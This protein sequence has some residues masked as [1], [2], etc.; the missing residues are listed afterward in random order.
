MHP[1]RATSTLFSNFLLLPSELN[2]LIKADGHDK[3]TAHVTS[4]HMQGGVSNQ[5]RSLEIPV[6]KMSDKIALPPK[7]FFELGY[8]P[9]DALQ[10]QYDGKQMDIAPLAAGSLDRI[11][12][13]E[14]DSD[15]IR[16]P[17]AWLIQAFTG[18]PDTVDHIESGKHSAQYYVDTFNKHCGNFDDVKRVLDFGCGCGR[19]L[20]RMPRNDGIQYFGVDLR[21][22]ALQ[23]LRQTM[24]EGRF[25]S[26]TAMPPLDLD[27]GQ[28][29]LIY[30]VSVLTH[31]SQ[32]QEWAWLDE[33]HRLLKV[34][35][36]LIVTFRAEDWV[37]Q[38]TVARQKQA[39]QNA[40]LANDGFCYQKHRYWE[41][42]FPEFY[43]G[44]Y[45]TVDY[46]RAQ[47][48][49]RFEILT[50]LPAADTPNEQNTAVMRK[51]KATD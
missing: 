43:S 3:L 33:W 24:P 6:G 38:F 49:K 23:W 34:G 7:A 45:Q 26:G 18:G 29:D 41:G 39:I 25:S 40:W 10:F 21:D 27:A 14:V 32:E 2:Q 46:V 48:G 44:T 16:I 11:S 30:S 1:N 20:S 13:C 4:Q 47:W 17:P 15:G 28:F 19:V 31:L 12:E 35:G 42:I 36:H 5:S 9:G 37:E 22:D 50:I 8:R 51:A